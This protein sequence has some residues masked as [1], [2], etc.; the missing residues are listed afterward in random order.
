MALGL[1]SSLERRLGLPWAGVGASAAAPFESPEEGRMQGA[2]A[3]RPDDRRPELRL[4]RLPMDF[5]VLGLAPALRGSP[6]SGRLGPC[7]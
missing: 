1:F 5:A 6:G 3:P 7:D 4:A 2:A